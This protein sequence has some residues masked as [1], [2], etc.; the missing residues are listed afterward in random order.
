VIDIMAA[1]KASLAEAEKEPVS[2]RKS[3]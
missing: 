2:T 1:L 3:A